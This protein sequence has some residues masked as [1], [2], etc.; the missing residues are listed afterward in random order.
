M[1]SRLESDRKLKDPT[2]IITP[3]SSVCRGAARNSTRL[4]LPT[5]ATG[6]AFYDI[7]SDMSS[8]LG[9]EALPSNTKLRLQYLKG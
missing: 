9:S 6:I 2:N 8:P 5:N 7:R 4:N 1:L 3:N